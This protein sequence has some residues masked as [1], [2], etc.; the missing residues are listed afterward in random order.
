ML[1]NLSVADGN[2]ER[3]FGNKTG[4]REYSFKLLGGISDEIP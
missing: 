4:Q 3:I 1:K 2:M